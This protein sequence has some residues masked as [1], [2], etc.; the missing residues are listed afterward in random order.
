MIPFVY[1]P[2]AREQEIREGLSLVLGCACLDFRFQDVLYSLYKEEFWPVYVWSLPLLRVTILLSAK[3]TALRPLLRHLYNTITAFPCL[4][5]LCASIPIFV[6]FTEL[7]T[8]A[9]LRIFLVNTH[10][11]DRGSRPGLEHE[12]R[13]N[14]C[15]RI[16]GLAMQRLI[17]Y[18]PPWAS[19]CN[20]TLQIRAM[21]A[22]FFNLRHFMMTCALVFSVFNFS[23]GL[24]RVNYS[25]CWSIYEKAAFIGMLRGRYGRIAALQ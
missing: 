15:P 21:R 12:V 1:R 16:K 13:T 23:I 3:P 14:T 17:S 24:R 5:R 10:K 2:N 25:L 7:P 22:F 4:A 8:I 20:E 11:Q 6:P 18:K 19:L 9:S